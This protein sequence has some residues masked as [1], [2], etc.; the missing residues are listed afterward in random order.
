MRCVALVVSLAALGALACDPPRPKKGPPGPA[1]QTAMAAEAAVARAAAAL[2]STGKWDEAHLAQ[3]L[4]NSGLA[5]Q[6]LAGLKSAPYWGVPLRGWRLGYD[7]LYAYIYPDSF[8][9]RRVTDVLDTLTLAPRGSKGSFGVIKLL[10]TQ[11]NLAAVLVGGTERQQQRVALA[12]RAG[13]P[14]SP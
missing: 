7:T 8:A 5:P 14:V 6:A 3:R 2:P 9:R 12:L 13:L 1:E 4:V 11:N 10:V